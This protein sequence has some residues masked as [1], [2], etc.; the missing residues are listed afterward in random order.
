MDIILTKGCFMF[1][2]VVSSYNINMSYMNCHTDTEKVTDLFLTFHM[3]YTSHSTGS[4]GSV[5]GAFFSAAS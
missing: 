3:F 5:N 2:L 4:T 1:F